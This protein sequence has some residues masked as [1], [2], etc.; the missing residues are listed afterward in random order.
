MAESSDDDV[1]ELV[2]D[3]DNKKVADEDE[4]KLTNFS[5]YYVYFIF[6]CGESFWTV[7]FVLFSLSSL[8]PNQNDFAVQEKGTSRG[9]KKARKAIL[10]LGMKPIPGVERVTMKKSKVRLFFNNTCFF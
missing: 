3:V 5:A 7:F 8:Q 6:V 2:D 1:P 9:E 10:K 4:V